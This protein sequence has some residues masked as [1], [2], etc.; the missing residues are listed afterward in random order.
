MLWSHGPSYGATQSETSF[1][2][3]NLLADYHCLNYICIIYKTYPSDKQSGE[4][5]IL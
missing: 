5:K 2:K 3:K 1:H 4:L